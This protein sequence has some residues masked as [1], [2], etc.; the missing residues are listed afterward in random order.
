MTAIPAE[1]FDLVR[2]AMSSDARVH[3]WWQHPNHDLD[4]R[5]PEQAWPQAPDAVRDASRRLLR[6]A[7][8]E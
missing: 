3:G 2:P 6:S 1:I 8:G 5:A 4:G 7:H